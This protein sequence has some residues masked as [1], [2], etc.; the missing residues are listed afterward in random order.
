[1][2]DLCRPSGVGNE[3]MTRQRTTVPALIQELES[4]LQQPQA[5]SPGISAQ[6]NFFSSPSPR[7]PAARPGPPRTPNPDPATENAAAVAISAKQ[8]NH[9][10][11]AQQAIQW[12]KSVTSGRRRPGFLI[13]QSSPNYTPQTINDLKVPDVK[14]VRIGQILADCWERTKDTEVPQFRDGECEVRRIWDEAVA[15]AMGW[16]L[17]ELSH[18]RHLLHQEPHVRGLGYEQYADEVEEESEA[19]RAISH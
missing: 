6:R 1:M 15:E 2:L 9:R 19:A 16:D 3:R 7:D 8:R 11:T 4:A 10:R 14:D 13:S 17:A 5:G 12:V 18:L